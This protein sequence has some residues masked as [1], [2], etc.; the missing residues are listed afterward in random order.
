MEMKMVFLDYKND[1]GWDACM[2]LYAILI[3]L[4]IGIHKTQFHL[5]FIYYLLL[6]G[7]GKRQKEMA[8]V[9]RQ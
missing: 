8:S 1:R 4:I 2:A 7:G 3:L 6:E 9:C 5:G